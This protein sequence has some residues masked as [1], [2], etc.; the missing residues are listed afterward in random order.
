MPGVSRRKLFD[1]PLGGAMATPIEI[2]RKVDAM[3][4]DPAERERVLAEHMKTPSNQPLLDTRGPQRPARSRA[5]M[6][7][8]IASKPLLW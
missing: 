1:K 5:A 3:W 7:G 2:A 4:S 8:R 6:F